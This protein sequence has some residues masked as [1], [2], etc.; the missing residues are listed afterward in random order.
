[1]RKF[2][3]LI[4][5]ILTISVTYGQDISDVSQ[6]SSGLL[7]VLDSKNNEL[8]RKYISDGDELSG[9]SSNIIVIKYKSGLVTVLDQKCNE[10]SRMYISDGDK[11]KNV[12]GN[13][14]VTRY[15]SGLVVTYDKKCN[16]ISRRYE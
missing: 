13:N 14:F 7:T 8:S 4:A 16:E 12:S 11:V 1:M 5:C 9:F 10:I 6:S 3:L 2:L 15:K